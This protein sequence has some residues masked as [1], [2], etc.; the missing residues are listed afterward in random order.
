MKKFKAQ[1][2]AVLI[3]IGL[4]L[5]LAAIC[6]TGYNLIDEYR[7]GNESETALAELTP[8]IP[9]E[10]VFSPDP[11]AEMPTI[12]IDGYDYIGT[13]KIPA[14]ELDLPVMA[15]WDYKRLRRAPCRYTGSVY[16]NDMVIC[17][18]NYP[19]HFGHIKNL[20]ENDAVIF[21]DVDGNVFPYHVISI[22]ILKPTDVELMETANCGLTLFTCTIGGRTRVT[23]RCEADASQQ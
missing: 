6:L 10:P 14:L 2:G 23:V 1:K 16:R 3:T 4:L 13:L 17:A 7:A 5:I 12:N 11:N 9:S 15:Q 20:S 8:F 21:T 19:R 18:H 22:E